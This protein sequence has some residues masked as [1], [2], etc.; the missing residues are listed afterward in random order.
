V[1]LAC[2]LLAGC[3][4]TSQPWSRN[5]AATAQV[6][7]LSP[8]DVADILERPQAR[9]NLGLHTLD[10]MREPLSTC[11]LPLRKSLQWVLQADRAAMYDVSTYDDSPAA[12]DGV[13]TIM[14][15]FP[16]PA[17]DPLALAARGLRGCGVPDT[18]AT[19]HTGY[20]DLKAVQFHMGA[21]LRSRASLVI[22][23]AQQVTVVVL[24]S[25][26]DTTP[27]TALADGLAPGE[28]KLVEA[29]AARTRGVVAWPAT[30]APSPTSS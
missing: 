20:G 4:G 13:I 15:G 8:G 26:P 12:V 2:S 24:T 5:E 17:G 22:L 27:A 6:P 9:R 25:H 29:V 30:P 1:A 21:P 7:V 16:T 10:D 18:T 19:V 3:A 28:K 23:P 11:G 14:A